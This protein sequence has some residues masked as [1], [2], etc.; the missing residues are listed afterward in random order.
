M[1]RLVRLFGICAL[2]CARVFPKGDRTTELLEAAALYAIANT[3]F[4][5]TAEYVALWLKFDFLRMRDTRA[6]SRIT[7]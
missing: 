5:G 6:H 7:D 3:V 1:V 2:V 4:G